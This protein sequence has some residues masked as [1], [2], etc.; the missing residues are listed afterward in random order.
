MLMNFLHLLKKGVMCSCLGVCCLLVLHYVFIVK[1]V[2]LTRM[3][4]VCGQ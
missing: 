2:C 1:D 4:C 3:L